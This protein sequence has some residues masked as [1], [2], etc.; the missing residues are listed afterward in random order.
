VTVTVYGDATVE[1]DETFYLK[2]TGA[3]G[4]NVANGVG[5][6]TIVN[7]DTASVAK[8]RGK[9]GR[10]AIPDGVTGPA[11]HGE[12]AVDQAP[13]N[14]AATSPATAVGTLP[15]V[16]FLSPTDT[17][18]TDGSGQTA[19]PAVASGA[20]P[21]TVA[22]ALPPLT[23]VATG[24][25]VELTTPATSQTKADSWDFLFSIQL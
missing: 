12:S 13:A 18:A 9:S 5:T 21:D 4:A 7:D 6:G 1:S 11:G 23:A 2:L 15:A 17:R 24:V 8:I 3:S 14:P 22:D 25:R 10:A 16:F 20:R 19:A